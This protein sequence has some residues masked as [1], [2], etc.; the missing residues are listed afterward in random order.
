MEFPWENDPFVL[1]NPEDTT[2]GGPTWENQSPNPSPFHAA[3]TQ[4]QLPGIEEL[5][6]L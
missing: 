3:W 5:F 6:I 1:C 2:P 4:D